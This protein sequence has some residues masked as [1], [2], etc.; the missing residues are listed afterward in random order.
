VGF[1]HRRTDPLPRTV[2]AHLERWAVVGEENVERVIEPLLM[3]NIGERSENFDSSIEIAT[4]QIG[5]ADQVE[6][7]TFTSPVGDAV[8]EAA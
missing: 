7:L 1:E 5:R 4:H 8:R 2:G 3:S 6:W